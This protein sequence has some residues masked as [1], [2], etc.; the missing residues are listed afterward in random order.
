[1][2]QIKCDRCHVASDPESAQ[3]VKGVLYDSDASQPGELERYGDLC[4][5]CLRDLE[6]W[7]AKGL[8]KGLA[9]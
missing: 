6:A 3:E 1:M 8:D 2:I 4:E 5:G 9:R 7:I